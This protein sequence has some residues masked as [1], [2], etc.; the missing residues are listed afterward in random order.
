METIYR[1]EDGQLF[2]DSLKA[3]NWETKGIH[4][5]KHLSAAGLDSA[6]AV[7]VIKNIIVDP[8][9]SIYYNA[10]TRREEVEEA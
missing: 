6:S 2:N 1:T 7:S 4:M 8:C 3:H 9:L 10:P 5:L